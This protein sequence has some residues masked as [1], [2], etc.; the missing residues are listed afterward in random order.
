MLS[1]SKA[2]ILSP[3]QDSLD[4]YDTSSIVRAEVKSKKM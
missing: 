3:M 1:L 2:S 4:P